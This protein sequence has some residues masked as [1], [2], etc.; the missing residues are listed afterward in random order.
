MQA[1]GLQDDKK[2]IDGKD[3]GKTWT[4]ISKDCFDGSRTD[5]KVS[6]LLNCIIRVR[7][8]D[9]VLIMFDSV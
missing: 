3:A 6:S 8:S 4:Q 5:N 7:L 1:Y 2:L 9:V